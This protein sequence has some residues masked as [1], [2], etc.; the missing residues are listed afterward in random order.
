MLQQVLFNMLK[1]ALEATE[2]E[3]VVSAGIELLPGVVRIIIKNDQVMA[4]MV[5]MQIFQ[6]SFS[7][8]GNSRGLGTY[9]IK[10]LTESYL[11]GKAQFSSVAGEGTKFWIDLPLNGK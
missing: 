8:K 6:R 9:S 1:N 11:K 3:G 2:N 7:T 10:L 4:D 5:R